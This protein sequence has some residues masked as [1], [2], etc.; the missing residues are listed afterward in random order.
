MLNYARSS[1]LQSPYCNIVIPDTAPGLCP[2]GN[3]GSGSMEEKE[4]WVKNLVR[5]II[6]TFS[7]MYYYYYYYY[8]SYK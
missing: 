8:H 6:C 2:N 7:L 3:D 5:D 4:E 1:S